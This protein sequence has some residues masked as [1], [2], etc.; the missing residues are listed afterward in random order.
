M[1]IEFTAEE[2]SI[3]SQALILMTSQAT[4]PNVPPLEMAAQLDIASALLKKINAK[5]E[6]S[7]A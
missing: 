3:L 6:P 2:V 5:P 7:A 1:Q 4:R